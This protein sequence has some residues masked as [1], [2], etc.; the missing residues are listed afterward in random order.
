FHAE[1]REDFAGEELLVR[2]AGDLLDDV[3]EEGVA[4]VAV[5]ALCTGRK[6][7]RLLAHDGDE[8]VEVNG[9]VLDGL[10]LGNVVVAWDSGGVLEEVANGD[11]VARR[12][13]GDVTAERVGDVEFAL[14]LEDDDGG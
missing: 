1:G 4:G 12:K 6:L 2:H 8:F 14:L 5:A 11:L 9:L 3:G 13:V 7:K 10:V